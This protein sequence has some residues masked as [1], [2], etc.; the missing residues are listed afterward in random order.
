MISLLSIRTQL[1]EV[2]NLQESPHRI[3]LAFAIGVFIA[4]SPTYGL[5]TLSAV[6]LAWVFRLNYAIILLGNFVN[7]PWTTIPILGATMWTGWFILGIPDTPAFSWD[8]LS[9]ETIMKVAMPYVLPFTLGACT[10]GL[11]CSLL[12][13]P[14]ALFMINQHKK[15][16]HISKDPT[17]CSK[18]T[19]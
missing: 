6:F 14:L 10:L 17:N 7:N 11:L 5:H 8:N 9:P 18:K 3:A 12:A 1:T 15:Q 2:L 13:Y 19:A 4:F 16:S